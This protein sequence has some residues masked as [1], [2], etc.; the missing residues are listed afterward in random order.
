[1]RDG[2]C[3]TI[4]TPSRSLNAGVSRPAESGAGLSRTKAEAM[5]DLADHVQDRQRQLRATDA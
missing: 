1:V 5:V 2:L 3:G 4:V